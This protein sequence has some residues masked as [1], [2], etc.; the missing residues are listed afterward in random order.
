MNRLVLIGNGFDLAHGLKTSYKDFI[1]WYW[2]QW[3]Y[4]LLHGLN[5]TESDGLCSFTL[6]DNINLASW[7]Y[8]W[9]FHFKKDDPFEPWDNLKVV[10]T[11]MGDRNLCDY[12]MSPF[13]QRIC[14]SVATKKWVDI[15]NEYYSLLTEEKMSLNKGV[16]LP[17]YKE[18]NSHLD[19]LKNQL[20]E[21]LK[22]ESKKETT[23]IKEIKDKIYRPILKRE[24]AVG[25]N[26]YYDFRTE[27]ENPPSRIMILNF[28]Y[29]KT[30]ELYRTKKVDPTIIYIHGRLDDPDSVIF[31]YGDELDSGFQKLKNLNENECLRHIKSIRYLESDNYRRML[32]FIESAPFQIC[33]MGH[34]CGNSDRTLLNTLF[35]HPNCVSVKPYYYKEKDGADHY[36]DMVQN[37]CRN[38]T[39]MKLMRNRVVTKVYCEP[40]TEPKKEENNEETD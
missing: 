15:E 32:E 39:D 25:S 20:I 36:L 14:K 40:L 17:D 28:N 23:V 8:V 33:I 30:P 12:T 5:K 19:I 9:G 7:G 11:A 13:L 6:K 31:G 24:I 22:F 4:R 35:E 16:I 2:N 10:N 34:S 21:Y 26:S 29:T 27:D 37:I 18:L 1:S 38:F 3:G